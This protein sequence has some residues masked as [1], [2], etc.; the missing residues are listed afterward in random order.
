MKKKLLKFALLSVVCGSM[1]LAVTSCKDYDDD[2]D[3]LQGQI[4]AINVS[5]GK[6]QELIA[7]GTVI[8]DVTKNADGL[9]FTLSDGKTYSVTNGT[10]GTDAKVWTIG[11]DGFWYED[12]VKTD[13]RA[14]GEN[15]KDGQNGQNGQNGEYYVPNANSGNFDIYRDGK[16]VKDSGISWRSGGSQAGGSMTAVYKGNMLILSGVKDADGKDVPVSIPV[17]TPL[18]D[19]AFIPSVMSSVVSYPTTD[20]PFYHLPDYIA[21]GQA[22]A[23]KTFRKL[24]DWDKSNIVDLLYRV[25]PM[26]A[27][28]PAEAI[29]SYINRVVTTRAAGD[30]K[31]LLNVAN[32]KNDQGVLAVRTTINARALTNSGEDIAAFQLWNGQD[33]FTTDYVHAESSAVDAAIVNTL[34]EG[35]HEPLYD[36]DWAITTANPENDAFVKQFVPLTGAAN[37]S[38][39]YDG[40]LDLRLYVDLWSKT[41]S[42]FLTSLGFDGISY[43]FSLPKEYKAADTQGTNQQWFLSLDETTGIVKVNSKNVPALTPAIGRTPVVRV[44]A[45]MQPNDAA[46]EP[47]MVA[48]AYIKIDITEKPVT[49]GKPQDPNAITMPE[50]TKLYHDLRASHTLIGQLN[51]TDVNNQ[52][53]G[54]YKLTSQNFWQYFGGSQNEYTVE[55]SVDDNGH[56]KVLNPNQKTAKADTDFNLTVDGIFCQVTLGSQATTTSN[57]K[58]EVNNN[59]RT[60][61]TYD[62]AGYRNGTSKGAKYTVTIRIK[63]DN[64]LQRG[65]VV[66]T[67]VFYVKQNT[68]PY[69]FNKYFYVGDVTYKGA[70]YKDCVQTLGQLDG[71]TW[72]MKMSVAQAFEMISNQNIFVYYPQANPNVSAISFALTNASRNNGVNCTEIASP[73]DYNV[74]LTDALKEEMKIAEMDYTLTLVNTEKPDY[75]FNVVFKNPFMAGES[76]ALVLHGNTIGGDQVDTKTQ[77]VVRAQLPNGSDAHPL[78]YS[79]VGGKLT[80]SSVA[81]GSYKLTDAVVSV[82][83]DFVKDNAYNSFKG[84]LDPKAT[85]SCDSATGIVKYDGVNITLQENVAL[86]VKATVTFKDL[87]E[88]DCLIPVNIVKN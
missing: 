57:I 85:L 83:Y 16:F 88:V 35:K 87:S 56:T 65:D 13:K 54:Y 48:S 32:L 10:P 77:V 34:N 50:V 73:R 8:T 12:G 61:W 79:Y 17:G 14:I 71:G 72:K 66:L 51:W 53:Y 62:K 21:D 1:P 67:Q 42:A 22:A 59:C 40:E 63:S 55:V 37:V 47:R 39:V 81:T 82:K 27:Y 30:R 68:R 18:G 78:I 28:I 26:D 60:D 43:K 45:F 15:G 46:A 24:N 33:P 9:V 76:K 52:I 31:N 20:K 4:D 6:L 38:L 70:T 64:N 41:K 19:I 11:Q 2:I 58:F 23:D 7:S 80:L 36:R 25:S 44:D 3:N 29:G 49:P 74:F 84:Q 75:L 69:N 86:T 5:V